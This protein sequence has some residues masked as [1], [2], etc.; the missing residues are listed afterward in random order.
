MGSP[1]TAQGWL[2]VARERGSDAG[3]LR[4]RTESVGAPYLAGYAVECA[5]KALL[6]KRGQAFPRQGRQ[7]HN[8]RNLWRK[9][10]FRL[11]D[12]HDPEGHRAYFV[13][14]WST[15][16][17]YEVVLPASPDRPTGDLVQA[18]RSLVGW[19]TGQM[20]RSGRRR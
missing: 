8:L 11:R 19:I 7:G 6:Q 9:T 15:D 16:L 1:T 2:A 18:A 10:G 20:K 4:S 17:R 12:L 3:A 13:E 14:E 5:L